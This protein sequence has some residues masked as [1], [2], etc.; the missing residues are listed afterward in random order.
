MLFVITDLSSI[1]IEDIQA[2]D[3]IHSCIVI[4]ILENKIINE[5]SYRIFAWCILTNK[6]VY[7]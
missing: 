5:I 4:R 1:I 3:V 2:G 6:I 7:S